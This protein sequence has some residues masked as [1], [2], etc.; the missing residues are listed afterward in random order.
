MAE[1]PYFAASTAT[2][3]DLAKAD[4]SL[5]SAILHELSFRHA[6]TARRLRDELT[7]GGRQGRS[8]SKS[9]GQ[10]PKLPELLLTQYLPPR[11]PIPP[12]SEHPAPRPRQNP[13][14]LKFTPTIEQQTAVDAFMTGQSLKITAFAGAGKTSTLK[15]MTRARE[16]RG[17]YLSFNRA[18]AA[19]A[20]TSFPEDVHCATTHS[21]AVRQVRSTHKFKRAKLFDDIGPMQ[22]AKELDLPVKKLAGMTK[23]TDV[24]QAYLFQRTVKAFCQ[25]DAEAIMLDHVPLSGRLTGLP[26]DARIEIETWISESAIGLW[27]RMCD[28][29]DPIPLGH[30]G[31]LKLWSLSRPRLEYEY[32]L[33]D[34]AQDTNAVVLSVLKAQNAQCVFVGDEHQQIYEWRGAVNAMN[35]IQTSRDCKITKSFRFGTA[36]AEAASG[37]LRTLGEMVPIEGNA[38]VLSEVIPMGEA[39]TILARTNTKVIAEALH[40]LSS[41]RKVHIVGGTAELQRLVGDVF[42]L[43]SGQP[44]SH[45]DFFGFNNWD[46]VVAFAE[47]EEGE[48]LLPFVS[49]VALHGPGRLWSCIKQVEEEEKNA[50]VIVS[51]AHKAKGREWDNVKIADD[52]TS[53]VNEEGL[54]PAEETRLFYVAITRAKK[55]LVV[56]PGVL[57]SFQK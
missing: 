55:R 8:P 49:L 51:T 45:P 20:K 22:L 13:S 3:E 41:G 40:A 44:G 36:I 25:S 57:A 17:L 30:D 1:R 6:K 50:Q 29:K 24:Q 15:L 56:D 47:T 34:E 23:L 11:S 16:G 10:H 9:E 32:I 21:V 52:F 43:Q 27:N 5:V 42:C 19:E 46:D 33:L 31:Y 12:K 37:V 48:D 53:I 39:D 38:T 35:V 7:N 54:V 2:L 14:P 26:E 4:P 28:R 18:I